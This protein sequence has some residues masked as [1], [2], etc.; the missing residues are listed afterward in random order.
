MKVSTVSVPSSGGFH[1]HVEQIV[2][3]VG[4]VAGAADHRVGAEGSHQIQIVVIAVGAGVEVVIPEPPTRR[5]SPSAADQVVVAGAA[6]DQVVGAPPVMTSLTPC[7]A[8]DEVAWR[9][10]AVESS[11]RRCRGWPDRSG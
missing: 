8:D 1:H 5:S 3:A 4:V 6:E 7:L 2:D 11:R 9:S 10:E